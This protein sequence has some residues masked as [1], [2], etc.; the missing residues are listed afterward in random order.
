MA[1]IPSVRSPS[2]DRSSWESLGVALPFQHAC[3]SLAT[4]QLI[5]KR[6]LDNCFIAEVLGMTWQEEL[7]AWLPE[8]ITASFCCNISSYL[9]ERRRWLEETAGFGDGGEDN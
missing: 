7:C 4:P 9:G 1:L 2:D 6:A 3:N 5:T 8:I